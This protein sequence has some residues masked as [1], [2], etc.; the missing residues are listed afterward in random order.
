VF[1]LARSVTKSRRRALAGVGCIALALSPFAVLAWHFGHSNSFLLQIPRGALGT[2]TFVR[3]G[4]RFGPGRLNPYQLV[5]VPPRGLKVESEE[6]FRFVAS[7]VVEAVLVAS[8]AVGRV[9]GVMCV[10]RRPVRWVCGLAVAAAARL[11]GM[12][13]N[14]R[15]TTQG[16]D[17]RSRPERGGEGGKD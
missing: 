16:E 17:G 1:R 8:P 11:R 10:C 9:E 6:F 15:L 13:A 2:D 3:L 5:V 14:V 12:D 4:R 7:R